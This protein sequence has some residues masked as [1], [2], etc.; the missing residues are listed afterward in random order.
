[1]LMPVHCE[2][3]VPGCGVDVCCQPPAPVALFL[4]SLRFTQ[5]AAMVRVVLPQEWALTASRV[6]PEIA[7]IISALKTSSLN[8]RTSGLLS[9]CDRRLIPCT[10]VRLPGDRVTT[11]E[12]GVGKLL[13][14]TLT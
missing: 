5:T 1:M 11:M 9:R 3:Q 4:T 14:R 6:V 2:S 12:F 10:R 13:R 8:V 7:T